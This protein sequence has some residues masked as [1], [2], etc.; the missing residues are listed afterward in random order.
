M[1]IYNGFATRKQETVY[2]KCLYYMFVIL[3]SKV[4][5]SV[6]GTHF[7]E[8]RFEEKFEKL[9][10][11][12]RDLDK[13]KY[14]HPRFSMWFTELADALGL[15]NK[16]CKTKKACSALKRKKGKQGRI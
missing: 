5:S 14:L 6:T 3:Q 16:A 7:D 11:K 8:F 12:I 1:S 15:K 13:N 4:A 2:L 9:Y 10:N